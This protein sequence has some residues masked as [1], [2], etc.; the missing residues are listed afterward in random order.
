MAVVGIDFEPDPKQTA[1]QA[2]ER[3]QR[4]GKE[5]EAKVPSR[6]KLYEPAR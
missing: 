4:I 3:A 2:S 6:E 1:A 5:I